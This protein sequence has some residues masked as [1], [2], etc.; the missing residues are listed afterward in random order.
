METPSQIN[1][2]TAVS[3][4][5]TTYFKVFFFLNLEGLVELEE[6]YILRK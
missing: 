2:A 4:T 1:A 6:I 3:E 5:F